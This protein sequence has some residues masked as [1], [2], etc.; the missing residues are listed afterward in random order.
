MCLNRQTSE[1]LFAK[2]LGSCCDHNP[3]HVVCLVNWVSEIAR[4]QVSSTVTFSN[5]VS[6]ACDLCKQPFPKP[7][8]FQGNCIPTVKIQVS[9]DSHL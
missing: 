1:N 8:N 2:D 6:F 9:G 5:I 3:I 7:L 4:R